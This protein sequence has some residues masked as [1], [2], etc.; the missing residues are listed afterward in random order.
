MRNP[1]VLLWNDE[2]GLIISAELV[3]ILTIAVLGMVVGLNSV[4]T[5]VNN[6]LNDLAGAFGSLNQ[7]F[8]YRG[9][10]KWGHASVARAGYADSR[11]FCD[12]TILTVT[13]GGVHYHAGPVVAAPAPV[14]AGPALPTPCSSGD[15]PDV[16]APCPT[17]TCSDVPTPCPTGDCPAVGEPCDTCRT[18]PMPAPKTRKPA[19]RHHKHKPHRKHG[20]HRHKKRPARKK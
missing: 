13:E 20:P 1:I 15:C 8:Y 19:T 14:A 10:T 5:S 17:G 18:P 9:L 12:C 2:R 7:S 6:E 4:S 16:P 11:D 3:L